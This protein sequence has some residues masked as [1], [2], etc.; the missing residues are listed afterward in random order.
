MI[1]RSHKLSVTRQ[2]KLL[3]ISRGTVYY[4]PRPIPL[5]DLR[6]MRRIDQLH[7][8]TPTAGSRMLRDMLRLEGIIV[9]RKHVATLMRRMGLEAIY[10]QPRTSDKH[11]Q[12]NVFAYLLRNLVI[13]RPNQ[14]WALDTTYIPLSSGFVYL[15]AVIDVATRAILGHRVATTLET[16]HAVDALEMAFTRHG[17][18]EIINT[19]QGSQFTAGDFVNAVLTRGCR[20]SMDGRGAWRD[21]VFIERFWRT[22]KYEEVYLKAYDTVG[23]ARHGIATFI[24]WYNTA[25]PHSAAGRIPPMRAYAQLLPTIKL[26]A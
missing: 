11:P 9:G 7:T 19:D 12:H 10:R 14:V 26:A 6:I 5:H 2:A 18:P 17:T 13:D 21:N 25:R 20:F 16:C 4:L 1:D 22:I 23:D 3:D 24:D 8:N 15:T